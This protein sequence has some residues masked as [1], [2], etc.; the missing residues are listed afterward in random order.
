MNTAELKAPQYGVQTRYCH[1][2][3][4]ASEASARRALDSLRRRRAKGRKE[5]RAYKCRHCL[6]WH[7]TS[8]GRE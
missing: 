7:L 1:K 3:G 4:Y 6:E 5:A 8:Y 2:I